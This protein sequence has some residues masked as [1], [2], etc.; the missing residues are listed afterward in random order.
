MRAKGHRLDV[1]KM[2]RRDGEAGEKRKG[3][4]DMKT[5]VRKLGRRDSERRRKGIEKVS[6]IEQMGE[7]ET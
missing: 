6:D 1:E 4:A 7:R 2:G 5:K 3:A